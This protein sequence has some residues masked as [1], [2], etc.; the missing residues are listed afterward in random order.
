VAASS[1][2][3][4]TSEVWGGQL[5]LGGLFMPGQNA[6]LQLGQEPAGRIQ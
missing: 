1:Q 6:Q 3:W 5:E 4:G 2:E